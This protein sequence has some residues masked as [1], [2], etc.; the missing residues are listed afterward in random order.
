[1][2]NK[3]F[4]IMVL[5]LSLVAQGQIKMV[6]IP[7]NTG[8]PYFEPLIAGFQKATADAG[9]DFDSV[10]P[11]TADPTSQLP[12]VKAQVQRRVNVVAISP[13]SPEALNLAF[14]EAMRRNVTV[15]CVDSDLTGNEQFR[16]ASVL[17]A[18]PEQIGRGQVELLGSLIGYAGKFAILSATTDAPN[19]NIW[20]DWMKKALND[21]KYSKMQL[22]DIVYGNDEPQKSLTE[23]EALLTRFPDLRGIIS[24]TTV[25]IASCAQAVETAG[26][27]DQ[28]QV[29]GLG[30]PNQMRRFIDNGTVKAFALWSPYDEGYLA[31]YLGAQIAS[32]KLKPAVGIKFDVPGLGPHEFRENNVVITGPPVVFTKKNIDQFHF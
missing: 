28:I 16:T 21:P 25:G 2:F 32:G 8:N 7:K 11:A 4:A 1:M 19:Q 29:T 22:V 3:L 14:K 31:G 27:A 13:N 12:L 24:P 30:T 6:Y 10:A 20:I 23:A 5:S 18:D 9:A 17:T 15:I 26:K